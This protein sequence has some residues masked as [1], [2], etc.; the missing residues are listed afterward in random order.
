MPHWYALYVKPRKEK[1][2]ETLLGQR[3]FEAFSPSIS[4]RRRWSDRIKT[5]E[6]TLFP[7]YVFCR[8]NPASFERHPVLTV[9]GVN[10]I[11]GNGRE[12][13]AIPED[14]IEAIRRAVQAGARLEPHDFLSAGDRVE[15]LAG[16]LAGVTGLFVATPGHQSQVV[17]N[18]ELLRRAVAV[19]VPREAVRPVDDR[20]LQALRAQLSKHQTAGAI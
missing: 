12:A 17:L 14:E 11:A 1:T 4:E 5:I 19:E 7:G 2:V 20:R 13:V 9:P 16:P 8:F 18:V 6:K 15:I 3:H 10:W